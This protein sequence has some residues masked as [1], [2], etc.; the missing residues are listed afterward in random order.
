MRRILRLLALLL[1]AGCSPVDVLNATI[2]SG[3]VS[4]ARS[5]PYAGGPRHKL[6]VY[7]PTGGG[8]ERPV[9][10]FFYGGN[11]RTGSKAMYPFLARML[12]RRGL[13]VVVPDYRL[14]PE[15]QFP[16]FL[17]DC[18]RA[19]AWT[20]ANIGRYGGD[21]NRVTLIGHSAGA[22]NAVMLGLDPALLH[23]ARADRADLA[24]VIGLA[25][26]YDF[27]PITDPAT[28]P[29]F[30]SVQG[31]PASQPINYVDRRNPPMLL[32]TGDADR[33]VGPRNTESL[34][35][36]IRRMGGS[37]ETKLYPGIGH[38][39]IITA[40]APL[41]SRRAPV[42]DDVASFVAAQRAR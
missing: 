2:P 8:S 42:L 18:A 31:G 30:A 32:L 21:A 6:D 41:F 13:V 1:L 10:V 16:S 27:A 4:V 26:P 9:A 40:F 14:Y 3:G 11:W 38:I 12:A 36:R 7:W 23:A 29:V 19:V 17:E 35:R 33:I 5:I 15:V 39:G 28:V 22:Y 25:G 37:V 20:L 34:A 24:G